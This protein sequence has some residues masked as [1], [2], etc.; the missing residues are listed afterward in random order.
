MS[1]EAAKMVVGLD[2]AQATDAAVVG[3]KGA[4]LAT[5]ARLGG[6]DVPAAVCVTTTAYREAVGQAP[7]MRALSDRLAHLWIDEREQI[8]G[9]SAELRATVLAQPIAPQLT[10]D[11]REALAALGP[12]DAPYAVRSSATTEDAAE[13]SFAGQHESFLSVIGGDAVLEHVRRCWASLFTEE[14]VVYRLRNGI[15]HAAAEM[16]VVVQRMVPADAAGVMFTA[17]P[18]SGNRTVTAIEAVAGLA[19]GLVAGTVLP[20]G[21]RVRAGVVTERTPAGC[22]AGPHGCPAGGAGRCRAAPRA[23]AR[24]PAG[25]RVVPGGRRH[26]GGPEP[27]DHDAV[28]RP[29]SGGPRATRVRVGRPPADDDRPDEA[30]RDLGVPAH[31]W[32]AD[33]RSR[34]PAVRRRRAAARRSRGARRGDRRPRH[35]RPADR[36]SARGGRRARLHR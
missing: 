35:V 31:R 13:A 34:Q 16:A 33:A 36:R 3:G 7:R 15:D 11:V 25:H 1:R 17:D 27:P 32:P 6:V 5:L 18:V 28:P 24:R 21:Y 2:D 22:K 19:D 29:G 9:V 12:A 30:P 20:D 8:T 10:A 26:L 23:R 14:A 4:S